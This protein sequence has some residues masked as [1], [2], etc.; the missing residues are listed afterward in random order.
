MSLNWVFVAALILGFLAAVESGRAQGTPSPATVV[1]GDTLEIGATTV[2][3]YGIDAPELG[4]FCFNGSKRYRCGFDAALTLKNLIGG[5]AV[6]CQPTPVDTSDRGQICS[7]ELVDLAEA[8]LRRGY[9]V[10]LPN[11]L[12]VYRRAEKEAQ[13][14]KIGIWR[15]EFIMPSEWRRGRRLQAHGGDPLQICDVKGIVSDK[16][17]K[18]YLVGSDPHYDT[19]EIELSR[20]ERF[21][22]SDDEAELAGWRRWPKSAVRQRAQVGSGQSN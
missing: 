18:V 17:E 13:R 7:V 9:A 12:A 21:F 11:A 6:E 2:R 14:S 15:G 4:Q 10:T 8:M 5:T 16:G 1:D 22:C 20:G 19:I 3:L